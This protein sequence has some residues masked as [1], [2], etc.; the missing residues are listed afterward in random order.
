[1]G[2]GAQLPAR[3]GEKWRLKAAG[4]SVLEA[5]LGACTSIGM[6]W[7][8]VLEQE[9]PCSRDKA[10]AGQLYTPWPGSA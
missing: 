4:F 6:L 3:E 9:A 5:L 10:R 8:A 1:M 7:E 2:P